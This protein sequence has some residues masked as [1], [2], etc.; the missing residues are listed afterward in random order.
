MGVNRNIINCTSPDSRTIWHNHS[1]IGTPGVNEGVFSPSR[2]TTS[3]FAKWTGNI[4]PLYT[5]VN[6]FATQERNSNYLCIEKVGVKSV[7]GEFVA[8]LDPS[9]RV[10]LAN[11]VL[12]ESPKFKNLWIPAVDTTN[13]RN[14]NF[15]PSTR[16]KSLSGT[17]E[18]NFSPSSLGYTRGFE[19]MS[20]MIAYRNHI[21]NSE[22]ETRQVFERGTKNIPQTRQTDLVT[23]LNNNPLTRSD[24]VKD[25]RHHLSTPPPWPGRE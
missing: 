6:E 15:A 21:K 22:L 23:T 2:N 1:R 19:T 4:D 3:S 10:N 8:D 7:L 5:C 12:S 9:K 25:I 20:E 24:R 13:I 14:L 11:F 16:A 17:R 18:E